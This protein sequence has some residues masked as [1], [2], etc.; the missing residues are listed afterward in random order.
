M[1]CRFL[2]QKMEQKEPEKWMPSTQAYATSRSA[3]QLLLSIHFI[4]H[5]AFFSAGGEGRVGE[6]AQ[7][8]SEM[9]GPRAAATRAAA[10]AAAAVRASNVA[11]RAA[12]A[13]AAAAA[14]AAA[15]LTDAGDGVHGVEQHVA[16][17]AV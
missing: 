17:S 7:G 12:A 10:A 4:A 16:L 9:Q 5:C 8:P 13:V 11:M 15:A 3:K 14:A 2:S 6:R 1:S